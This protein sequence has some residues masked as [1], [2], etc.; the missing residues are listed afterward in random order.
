MELAEEYRLSVYQDLGKLAD[1]EQVHIVRNK[2]T[3]RICVRKYVALEL[4]DIYEF[5]QTNQSPYLPV[6]YECIRRETDLVVIEEY[7][8]GKTLGDWLSDHAFSEE[9]VIRALTL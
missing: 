6:I 9:E 7:L 3:G 1:K 5:L 4:A 2:V 8:A